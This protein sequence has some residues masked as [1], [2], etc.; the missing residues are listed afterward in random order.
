MPTVVQHRSTFG[1]GVSSQALAFLSNNAAGNLLVYCGGV[2]FGP[3]PLTAATDT[4]TNTIANATANAGVNG[5]AGS[6]RVDYVANSHSGANTV[7][8]H[9]TTAGDVHIHIW[10]ISGCV[11]ISPVGDSGKVNSSATA[12]VSTTGS[13]ALIGDAVLAFFYDD[14]ANDALVAGSGYG[15][16]DLSANTTG[17]DSALSEF[18]T[19]TAGGTQNATL[20]GNGAHALSQSIVVFIQSAVVTTTQVV[21]QAEPDFVWLGGDEY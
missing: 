16:S 10:E 21:N 3:G 20:T 2:G 15:T 8:V 4:N 6:S 14:A 19:A 7:T 12:S 11:T 1:N 18:K 13:L 17:G 5:G 9:S